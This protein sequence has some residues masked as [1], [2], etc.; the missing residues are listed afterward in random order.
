MRVVRQIFMGLGLIVL[1]V[2]GMVTIQGIVVWLQPYGGQSALVEAAAITILGALL[3]IGGVVLLVKGIRK[4]PS[5]VGEISDVG[6][7]A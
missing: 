3:M 7:E 6:A 2:G 1:G 4:R 5:A